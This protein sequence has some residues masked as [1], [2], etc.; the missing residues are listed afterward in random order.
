M[1]FLQYKAPSA[2]T[3]D[4]KLILDAMRRRQ[5]FILI[6]DN[7]TRDRI[8][9]NI[10]SLQVI[11]PSI[12]TFHENMKYFSI[13]AKILQKHVE[14][15]DAKKPRRRN[16]R[17]STMFE[18]LRNDWKPPERSVVRTGAEKYRTLSHPLT[19]ELAYTEL[20]LSA[21]R[22]FPRLCTESPL[23][24]RQGEKLVAFLDGT[25]LERF[26]QTAKTLGFQNAKLNQNTPI[27]D[28]H[29]DIA[30][31]YS[32]PNTMPDWRGGRP[33]TAVFKELQ[34][35]SFLPILYAGFE[36]TTTPSP[37]FVQNDFVRAFF[38]TFDIQEHEDIE[39]RDDP[40]PLDPIHISGDR[41]EPR[42]FDMP[43]AASIDFTTLLQP[44]AGQSPL[45]KK[46]GNG[47]LKSRVAK[48]LPQEKGP[49]KSSRLEAGLTR[50]KFSMNIPIPRQNQ[51][52]RHG[53]QPTPE[54][55]VPLLP[56]PDIQIPA[57]EPRSATRETSE[58]QNPGPE[59]HPRA[60]PPNMPSRE[61]RRSVQVLRARLQSPRGDNTITF[62]PILRKRRFEDFE[63][64]PGSQHDFRADIRP[65]PAKNFK[66]ARFLE[67]S[68]AAIRMDQQQ[69][70]PNAEDLNPGRLRRQEA[71]RSIQV[72]PGM[73]TSVPT[74]ETG[75]GGLAYRRTGRLFQTIPKEL[76]MA[77]AYGGTN[78]AAG[79]RADAASEWTGIPSDTP[80]Q[81]QSRE[82][83]RDNLTDESQTN[84]T[85]NTS[86]TNKGHPAPVDTATAVSHD[87]DDMEGYPV[88]VDVTTALSHDDDDMEGH[89]VPVDVPTAVSGDDELQDIFFEAIDDMEGYPVPVDVTTAV[90]HDDDDME[91]HPVPVDATTAVSH[92]DDSM[93]GYPIPVD[94]TTEVSYDDEM[95]DEFD[96]NSDDDMEGH[97]VPVDVTTAVSHNDDNMET[98]LSALNRF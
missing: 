92:D 55:I 96:E 82:S 74:E 42:N 86:V 78:V 40:V 56:R 25:Y 53:Q 98:L 54:A 76:Q 67:N 71:A 7:D 80:R 2:S 22:D 64:E 83:V 17:R 63:G 45:K 5:I 16:E 90:S 14:Y 66:R 33:P 27:I 62:N 84:R 37:R 50:E 72:P 18:N 59:N 60:S 36:M 94:V 13:G 12:E 29:Q 23:Q 35:V 8:L 69:E 61:V 39:M 73:Q 26:R 51:E 1:R 9:E 75:G 24:G 87:D 79:D 77:G 85:R 49:S 44:K 48:G 19:P 68:L 43:D 4:R 89:P 15:V 47:V 52:R 10:L 28:I 30:A 32:H 65:R 46:P 70:T 81:T 41:S 88:P 11:I 38:G 57:P 6:S 95:Q 21:L 97:P 34:Q 20:F 58:T 3:D 93:E 31:P 91:G